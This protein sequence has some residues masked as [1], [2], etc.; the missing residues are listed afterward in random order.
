[1]RAALLFRIT[2]IYANIFV[3]NVY[4]SQRLHE[5]CALKDNCLVDVTLLRGEIG[6]RAKVSNSLRKHS[7]LEKLVISDMSIC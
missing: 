7:K 5:T 3:P 2:V 1:M 6:I 4:K